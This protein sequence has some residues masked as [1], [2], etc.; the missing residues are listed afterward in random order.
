MLFEYFSYMFVF[1]M[2]QDQVEIVE[3]RLAEDRGKYYRGTARFRFD[4]LHFEDTFPRDPQDPDKKIVEI[5]KGKFENEGCLRLEPAN[6]I[7]AVIDQSTLDMLIAESPGISLGSLLDNPK[8]LPPEIKCP[9][10]IKIECLQGRH[11]V[12]A[13]REYLPPRD[14]WWTIDLYLK[15]KHRY[16]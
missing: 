8:N 2:E 7:P 6:H 16:F 3:K 5:L 9:N 14:W 15:G 11:R 1:H 10:N 13:G 4:Y 12:E